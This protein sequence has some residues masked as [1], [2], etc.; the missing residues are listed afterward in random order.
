MNYKQLLCGKHYKTL[1][2][3]V[4]LKMHEN[5]I[6]KNNKNPKFLNWIQNFYR[7]Q[8]KIFQASD[9]TIKNYYLTNP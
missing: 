8:Y 2:G 7:T 5:N 9:R 1:S 6:T 4:P 3:N